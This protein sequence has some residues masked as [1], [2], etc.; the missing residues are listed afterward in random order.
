MCEH[1]RQRAQCKE[2]V[3]S[4]RIRLGAVEAPTETKVEVKEEPA[5]VADPGVEIKEELED[6]EDP[7]KRTTRFYDATSTVRRDVLYKVY[8]VHLR[9]PPLP[10]FSSKKTALFASWYVA[11]FCASA[12]ADRHAPPA[13]TSSAA[14]L[15]G[16]RRSSRVASA[17]PRPSPSAP[18]D[19]EVEAVDPPRPPPPPRDDAR[20]SR[21]SR[22]ARSRSRTARSLAAS[23]AC[24][25]W[26]S[27]ACGERFSL[28]P[29]DDEGVADEDRRGRS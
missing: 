28:G 6:V 12:R 27:V 5:D 11:W 4:P 17:P 14:A 9:A 26:T 3:R 13:R 23:R 21:S 19:E 1:G 10:H 8:R 16:I 18:R 20:S 22:L 2:C 29:R 7:G 15:A 25:A 24:F